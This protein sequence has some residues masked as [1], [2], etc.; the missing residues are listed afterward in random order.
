[1]DE[2]IARIDGLVPVIELHIQLDGGACDTIE[3]IVF[4]YGV[5]GLDKNALSSGVAENIV[6]NYHSTA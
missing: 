5:T 3:V 2:G 1:M 4:D 6:A